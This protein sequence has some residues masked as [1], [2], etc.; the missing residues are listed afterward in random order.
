MTWV[1]EPRRRARQ[2]KRRAKPIADHAPAVGEAVLS[3][4]EQL[5]GNKGRPPTFSDEALE[6]TKRLAHLRVRSG[7]TGLS[8]VGSNADPKK[9]KKALALTERA[10]ATVDDIIGPKYTAPGTVE[11]TLQ[12]IHSRGELYFAIYDSIWGGRVKCDI[13]EALKRKA[14]DAFD[15]RVLVRGIVSTDASG[16]PRQ[17][18]VEHIEALPDRD[19]L[20]QSIRGLD[21]DYTAGLDVADYVTKR[22]AGDV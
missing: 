22:W 21:P 5:E 9:E 8:L 1:G 11:G 17:V 10:A 2:T 16:H 4:I 15:Q 13:P 14:L 7:I 19:Q 6:A 12:A 18:K 3:G 20:P